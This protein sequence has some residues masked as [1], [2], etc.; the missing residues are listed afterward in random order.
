MLMMSVLMLIFIVIIIVVIVM[1][2]VVMVL[3]MLMLLML[4]V[5]VII[6]IVV[7]IMV[8]AVEF[9]LFQSLAPSGCSVDLVE[10]ERTGCEDVLDGDISMGGL[11]HLD[12]RMESLD[13]LPDLGQVGL[14]DKV[15]LV[16]D[17]S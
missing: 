13:D 11:D 1:V 12:A 4:V 16:D 10:I 5:M 3:V 14:G 6:V 7:I 2:M 8:V 17:E 9:A 15:D